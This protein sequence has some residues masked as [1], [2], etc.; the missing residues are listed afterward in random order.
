MDVWSLGEL[1][2]ALRIEDVRVCTC[3]EECEGAY[4]ERGHFG[5]VEGRAF[6]CFGARLGGIWIVI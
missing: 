3:G 6:G 2:E 1:M 5:D 4:E